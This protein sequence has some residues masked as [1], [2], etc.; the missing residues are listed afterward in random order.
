MQSRQQKQNSKNNKLV[1]VLILGGEVGFLIALPI[2][3]FLIL[4]LFLDKKFN[5][6]PLFLILCII[7]AIVNSLIETYYLILPFVEKKVTKK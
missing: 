1:E 5:T 7:F 2:I 6:F 4:G 3:F